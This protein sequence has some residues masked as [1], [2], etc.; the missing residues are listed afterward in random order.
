MVRIQ[1]R[2]IGNIYF[3]NGYAGNQ[4]IMGFGILTGF[5]AKSL[6]SDA[7]FDKLFYLVGESLDK[8]K[9]PFSSVYTIKRFF[10]VNKNLE[11]VFRRLFGG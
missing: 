6:Y 7:E 10:K 4:A 11:Y 8:I 3:I 9:V 5:W 2:K 1:D